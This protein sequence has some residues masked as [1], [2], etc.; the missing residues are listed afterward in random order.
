M[1]REFRE[2]PVRPT[3]GPHRAMG[4]WET[5][6]DDFTPAPDGYV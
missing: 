2:V 1:V 6:L 5:G 4:L 3:D